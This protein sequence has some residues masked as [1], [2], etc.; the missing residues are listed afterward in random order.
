MSQPVAASGSSARGAGSAGRRGFWFRDF[1]IRRGRVRVFDTGAD[2][3]LD[4]TLVREAAIWLGYHLVVRARSWLLMLSGREGPRIW[5]TPNRPR[6][7]YLVWSA[8]AWLGGRVATSPQEADAHFAFEDATWAAPPSTPAL[9]GQCPDIS[10]SRVAEV[11]EQVFGYPLTV[12]PALWTGPAVEKGELNGAHDGRIVACP[13][14]AEPG[15][16]YQRLVDTSD[17]TFTY[18]LRTPCIGGRPAAVWIKRKP[19][20]ARFSIHNLAVTLH[21]PEAVFSVD[22]LASIERFCAAMNLDWGGLDILRDRL[23]GRIYIV[24][25]NKTD[26]GPIIALSWR[27]KLRSTELL[28]AALARLLERSSAAPRRRGSSRAV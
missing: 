6:P 2:L 20:R 27:D 15:R 4:R 7:W 17:G 25:V 10:K 16:C 22:E 18:D 1:R 5:F 12:D 26:V 19:A 3:A 9:N 14:P 21:R 23:S 8:L 28:A 13:T 11:F 24:D